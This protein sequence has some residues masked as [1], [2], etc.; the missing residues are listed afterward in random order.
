MNVQ[1]RRI[2]N[3]HVSIAKSG[4]EILEIRKK[5][6]K[7]QNGGGKEETCFSIM[8]ATAMTMSCC[9]I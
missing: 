5:D 3:Y 8:A 4:G 2:S 7:T 9:H 1:V 6:W